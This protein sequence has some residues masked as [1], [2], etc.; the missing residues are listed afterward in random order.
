VT[1]AVIVAS[2]LFALPPAP[3]TP[4]D[5]CA[6]LLDSAMPSSLSSTPSGCASPAS[7]PSSVPADA[8]APPPALRRDPSVLPGELG[9]AAVIVA[10]VGG[11]AVLG[12]GVTDPRPRDGEALVRQQALLVSGASLVG[13]AGL[14]GAGAIATVVF[15]PSTGLLRLPLFPGED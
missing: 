5:P 14:V 2:A 3:A 1:L 15:D 9:V 12:S 6:R 11:S 8:K 4:D 7:L 10:L 13:L